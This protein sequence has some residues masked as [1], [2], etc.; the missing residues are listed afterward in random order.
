MKS[1]QEMDLNPVIAANLETLG[2]Q[3]PSPIQSAA[4]P[5]ILG[6]KEDLIALA[7]TGTGK[8]AAFGLPVLSRIDTKRPEVQAIIVCPT[9][10]L[11][12]Q[13]FQSL[14]G[15]GK[16]LSGLRLAAVYGGERI[17]FQIRALKSGAQVVV[18]TPG[19]VCDLIRRKSLKLG[20][21]DWLILDE[22]DEMMDMGFKE[23]LNTILAQVP[24]TR[25]TLLFS[26]TMS[27]NVSLIAK[28]YLKEAKEISVGEKNA[29]AANVSHE[30]FVV[31]DRDRFEALRRILDSITDIYGILFCRTRMET[32]ELADKLKMAGYLAEPLHGDI[33]QSQRTKIMAAFS[34]KRIK[35]LVATDVA[36]RGIDV[37]GLTHIINYNFPEQNESYTHRSG[38]TG[39]AQNQGI[40]ISLVSPWDIWRIRDVEKGLGKKFEYKKVPSQLDAFYRRVEGFMNEIEESDAGSAPHNKRLEGILEKMG[41]FT[42]EELLKKVIVHE[43][44]GPIQGLEEGRDL[45]ASLDRAPKIGSKPRGNKGNFR[46]YRGNKPAGRYTGGS[47]RF[48]RR[49]GA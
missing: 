32:Q 3:V 41:R 25:R 15:F 14:G 40:S 42:K 8:T 31:S 1:F 36:A 39:R 10:E 17:D 6:E 7:Q 23:D 2:Y 45:N 27:R 20:S 38:R 26:A 43:F 34:S 28:K 16:G 49:K 19:R 35:L 5:F 30:Y 44:V 18:G 9:R 13:T 48:S 12:L 4:I 22:A 46:G 29:G 21:V 47:K 33:A 11:C 24:P 37:V